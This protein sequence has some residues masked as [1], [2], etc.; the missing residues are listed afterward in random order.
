MMNEESKVLS[1]DL[2]FYRYSRQ[3]HLS[4]IREE[5]ETEIISSSEVGIFNR[6]AT[7][8]EV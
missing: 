8:R 7:D 6:V 5:P 3:I 2:N 4:E 1:L